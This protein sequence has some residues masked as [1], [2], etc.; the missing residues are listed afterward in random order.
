MEGCTYDEGMG[1]RG[2]DVVFVHDMVDLFEADDL[3]LFENLDCVELVI[4][5][6]SRES[7]SPEGT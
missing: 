4:F 6:I 7:D 5:L 1:N 2:E 3:C